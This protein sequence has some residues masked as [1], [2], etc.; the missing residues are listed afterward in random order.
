MIGVTTSTDRVIGS[1]NLI[2]KDV[3]V[4]TISVFGGKVYSITRTL[5]TT[6]EEE[7]KKDKIGFGK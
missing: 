4:K 2:M 1:D 5:D 3:Y 6:K 7:V